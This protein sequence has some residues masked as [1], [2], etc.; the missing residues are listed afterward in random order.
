MKEGDRDMSYTLNT[1]GE[2]Q[3]GDGKVYMIGKDYFTDEGVRGLMEKVVGMLNGELIEVEKLKGG[4][5]FSRSEDMEG[6][7]IVVRAREW[8]HKNSEGLGKAEVEGKCKDLG[9]RETVNGDGNIDITNLLGKTDRRKLEA[10]MK[11]LNKFMGKMKEKYAED[12]GKD[13]GVL[14]EEEAEAKA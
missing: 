5:R 9:M 6:D 7:F 13:G 11:K 8:D 1:N 4:E 14:H 3:D 12:A 2:I 10:I